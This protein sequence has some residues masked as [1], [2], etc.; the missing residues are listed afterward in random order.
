MTTWSILLK[1]IAECVEEFE[2]KVDLSSVG[3][4]NVL[5]FVEGKQ[6]RCLSKCRKNALIKAVK[7]GPN[8]GNVF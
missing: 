6:E 4:C 7:E 5:Q 8:A 2:G 3:Y 1:S